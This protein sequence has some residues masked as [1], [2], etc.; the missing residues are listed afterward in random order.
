MSGEKKHTHTKEPKK[1][2][3]LGKQ[4]VCHTLAFAPFTLKTRLSQGKWR[5]M[6]IQILH[7][8]KI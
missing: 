7:N 3:P 5:I 2:P 8:A 6:E 1:T 4:G